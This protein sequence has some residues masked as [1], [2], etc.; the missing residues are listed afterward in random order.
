MSRYPI[1]VRRYDGKHPADLAVCEKCGDEFRLDPAEGDPYDMC[2]R[3]SAALVT[4]R[5]G[6]TSATTCDGQIHF[7]Y[8]ETGSCPNCGKIGFDSTEVE[9][10]CSR[11]CALQWAHAKTVKTAAAMTG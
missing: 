7:K 11:R 10:C 9:G 4:T 1:E 6:Q 8:V 3:H 5:N 2:L